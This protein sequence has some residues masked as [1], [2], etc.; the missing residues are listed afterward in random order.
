MIAT[1]LLALAVVSLH[2]TAMGA[3]QFVPD[4]TRV[5]DAASLSPTSLSLVVAGTAAIL[6]GMCLVA[7]L[8]DRQSKHE[9]LQQKLMLDAALENMSQGLCMYDT[10]GRVVLFNERYTKMMKLSAAS[11][12]GR[13]LLELLKLRTA[14]GTMVDDAEELFARVIADAR[15]GKSSS[16]NFG[17]S[18][19]RTFRVV[20]H[21][22]RGGGWVSTFEDITESLKAQAQIS[23]LARHDP[24]TD[25][26]N[27]TLFR[28]QLEQA[29]RRMTD[30]ERIAVLCIDLDYFK[31]V[32]DSLGHRI[33]DDLLKEVARRLSACIRK[34]DT[35]SRLGGDEFAIVQVGGE[36]QAWEASI[37]ASR[38]VEV[39]GAPYDIQGH[40]VVIGTSIGISV[41]PGDG[42]DPDQLLK[43]AAMAL[44]RAKA[45]GRCTYRFFEP[46]M[47]ARAQ[48]RRLLMLDLRAALLRNEFEVHYQP[49]HDLET[50]RIVCFEALVRWNHPLRG[51]I[52]PANFIPLAEE[53]GLIVPIGEWVLRKACT[54]AASWSQGV[55][56]AV[57]LSPLQFKNRN[58]VPSVFAALSASGLAANRLELEITESSSSCRTARQPSQPCTSFENSG[59]ESRW[60]TSGPAIAR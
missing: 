14:G 40:Q 60:T 31:D 58:L 43:N 49:I 16:K 9:L 32:N 39:V 5:L 4:P 6:L 47:D 26:A 7:A 57:N 56:V 13:S 33:G 19:G 59:C 37:L 2:F 21:P 54:D 15:V 23:H 11:L 44:H 27:R 52:P 51:I 10:D 50:D 41:T 38:I 35:V 48:A 34:S 3:V 12:K 46:G 36:T 18:D 20:D 25:L 1:A 28:E 22:M 17:T 42:T 53:T 30:N 8:S 45:D 55:S 24:L 29:L